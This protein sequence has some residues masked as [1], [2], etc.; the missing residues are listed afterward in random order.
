M[1]LRRRKHPH[2]RRNQMPAAAAMSILPKDE[3]EIGDDVMIRFAAIA[4]ILSTTSCLDYPSSYSV[5]VSGFNETRKAVVI[6]AIDK[7]SD[8]TD[9]RLVVYDGCDGNADND[10]CV[11]GIDNAETIRR[12][13]VD[14]HLPRL[15]FTYIMTRQNP[16]D[17]FGP[18][19][20]INNDKTGL[21]G[22][23]SH[24][25]QHEMGHAMGL[26]HTGVGTV[27]YYATSGIVETQTVAA[28]DV[29][30][31]DVEQWR[32]LRR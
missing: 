19:V 27:M 24:V 5:G 30:A 4:V 6:E 14:A 31:A 15:G 9:A 7:W 18:Q 17:P 13:F 1:S 32:R 25:V 12:G 23:L 26:E 2:H 8:A 16:F 21:L 22:V 11:Y 29:T 20:F 10:I 28:Q 3:D